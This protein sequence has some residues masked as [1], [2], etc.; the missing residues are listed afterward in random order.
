MWSNMGEKP[1]Q[2]ISTKDIGVFA[3]KAFQDPSAPSF[4]NKAISL[5]GDE[6]TQD[7]ACD[8]FQKVFG[9]R[10]PMVPGFVGSIVQ[11]KIP[12][13]QSMSDWFRVVGFGA[14]VEECRRLNPGLQDFE[15]W[16]RE[17]SG[18]RK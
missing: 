2:L 9:K 6:L 16:L 17:S 5:T 3:A 14:S 11:W 12:Q 4:H 15:M 7:K 13:L 18:F 1:L 8:I 10:M